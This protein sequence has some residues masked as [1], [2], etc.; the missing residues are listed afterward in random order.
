M[1][2]DIDIYTPAPFGSNANS[3]GRVKVIL[4]KRMFLW[5]NIVKGK[6]RPFCKFQSIKFGELYIPAMGWL[7]DDKMERKISDEVIR[8]L[9]EMN[10]I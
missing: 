3:L 4:N 2:I 7:E 10:E 9:K 1:E 6:N 8:K 5:M